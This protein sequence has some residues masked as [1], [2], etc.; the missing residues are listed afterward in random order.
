MKTSDSYDEACT[1]SNTR[2]AEKEQVSVRKDMNVDFTILGTEAQRTFEGH[3]CLND[4][5]S[6]NGTLV[7][8]VHYNSVLES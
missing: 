6:G 5:T 4:G 8:G 2:R 7:N 1:E 3:R